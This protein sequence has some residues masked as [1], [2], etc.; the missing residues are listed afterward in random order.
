M[1]II[2]AEFDQKVIIF[3]AVFA[4]PPPMATFSTPSPAR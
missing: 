2:C 4:I 1:K 3:Q